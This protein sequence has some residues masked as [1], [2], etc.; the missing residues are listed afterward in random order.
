MT[1]SNDMEST[2]AVQPPTT[3]AAVAAEHGESWTV[4]AAL[5]KYKET[6][7]EAQGLRKRLKE[8]ETATAAQ[9]AERQ[10]R[11]AAALAEQGKWKELYEQTTADAESLRAAKAKLDALTSAAAEANKRRI[12]A[13]PEHLRS[14]VPDYDDP[15]KLAEWLDA[16]QSLLQKPP[17]P[18]LDGGKGG[19]GAVIMDEAEVEQQAIRLGVNPELYRRHFVKIS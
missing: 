5:A 19:N 2:P 8:L 13:V 3:Q 1:E 6:Q 4:D 18:S 16:S 11:E 17:A 7:K 12:E 15:F 9:E 10:Q 14:L